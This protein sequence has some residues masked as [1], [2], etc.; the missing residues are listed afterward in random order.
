MKTAYYKP[1][2]GVYARGN[3]DGRTLDGQINEV[4]HFVV[5]PSKPGVN[6]ERA[7]CYNGAYNCYFTNHEASVTCPACLE[8]L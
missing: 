5:P 8:K 2:P 4:V 3:P 1:G 7:L 6:R